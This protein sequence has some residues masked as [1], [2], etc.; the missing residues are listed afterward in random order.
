[1][2][3]LAGRAWLVVKVDACDDQDDEDH[4]GNLVHVEGTAGEDQPRFGVAA[5][6]SSSTGGASQSKRTTCLVGQSPISSW[7]RTS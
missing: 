1:V 2:A 4:R 6:V 7:V 3:L 5:M